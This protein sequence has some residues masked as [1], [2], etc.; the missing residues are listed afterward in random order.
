M[1]MPAPPGARLVSCRRSRRFG[2]RGIRM[3]GMK[4]PSYRG[5]I[6]NQRG[7]ALVLAMVVLS[8]LAIV[9]LFLGSQASINRRIASDEMVKS[10]ALRYAEAGIAEATARIQQGLG[11]DP[12]AAGAAPKVVQILNASS[13]GAAGADTTLLTTGQPGGQW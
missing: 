10:K 2:L 9:A 5:A 13:V 11:P 12:Y 4:S 1:I 6:S 7:A 3:D 8:T